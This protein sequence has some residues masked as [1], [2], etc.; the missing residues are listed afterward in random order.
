[1]F[2]SA[3]ENARNEAGFSISARMRVMAMWRRTDE[4][5]VFYVVAI[6]LL[7]AVVVPA[8]QASRVTPVIERAV[9]T[10][11]LAAKGDRLRRPVIDI[12][13]QGAAY[14]SETTECLVAIARDSGRDGAVRI[15]EFA[16]R[17]G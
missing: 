15:V 17:N 7:C 12:A 4:M 13:C 8:W 9:V 14:G 5:V 6:A 3:R 10:S 2:A 16:A 11:D 1:M